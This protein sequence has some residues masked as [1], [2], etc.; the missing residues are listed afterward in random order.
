MHI[1]EFSRIGFEVERS[2]LSLRIWKF[3]FQPDLQSDPSDF[4][5]FR[6]EQTFLSAHVL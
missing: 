6:S 2:I 3:E 1:A 5:L 4:F